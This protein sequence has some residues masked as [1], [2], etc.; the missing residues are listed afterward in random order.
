MSVTEWRAAFRDMGIGVTVICPGYVAS[1]MIT[2]RMPFIMP[3][4]KAAAVVA[5][6]LANN[7]ARITFPWQR[8]VLGRL[9]INLPQFMVDR[10]NWPRG[11]PRLDDEL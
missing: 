9:A 2:R 5:R 10:L 8:V 4:D 7:R 1:G 3:A 11:V 6:G